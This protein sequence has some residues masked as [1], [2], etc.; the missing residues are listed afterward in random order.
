MEATRQNVD[1]IRSELSFDLMLM[2]NKY[3]NQLTEEQMNALDDEIDRKIERL[4]PSY[5]GEIT[6][7]VVFSG[8]LSRTIDNFVRSL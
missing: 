6:P 4:L 5:S 7:S 2:K 8:I 1:K 3:Y